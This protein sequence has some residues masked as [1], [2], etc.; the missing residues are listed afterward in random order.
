MIQKNIKQV[1][2]HLLILLS[3]LLISESLYAQINFV[4]TWDATA[5]EQDG[6][7]LILRPVKDVKQT[8]QYLDGLGRPIQT[9]VKQGSLQTINNEFADM[10]APT[11]YDEFG[12]E[13]FKY[14]PFAA[15]NAGGNTSISNGLYKTNALVQQAAFSSI[16]YPGET[17]FYSKT[18]FE[19]SPLNR[20]TDSYAPGSSWA[21]SENNTAALQR[22]VQM[23]Y[24]I[25]TALDDVKI[26]NV[27]NDPVIGNFGTYQVSTNSGGSY[28]AGE[29]Y[30]NITIDE[31]KKQVIE[32][33]D[34][35]GKVIL[36]KVQL[37]AADDNGAGAN[38]VGWLCTYYIY[39]DLN[40]L[41]CVIQP[42]GVELISS[43]WALNDP[44]ILAEQCFRYEYDQR[45]RMII[46]KVPGAGEVYMVYDARD[47]LIMTQDA[48]LRPL[49]YWLVT[50]YDAL[51]R[52]T[53]TGM[54]TDATAFATHLTNTYNSSNYP[55]TTANYEPLSLTHYDDYT[56]LPAGLSA[57]Y[58][59]GYN[60]YFTATNNNNWPYPQMPVQSSATKGMVTWSQTKV[61]GTTNQYLNAVIFYDEKGRAIQTQSINITGGTDISTTQYTWAG[62]PLVM[63]Q[64]QQVNSAANPQE[65]IV[66]SKMEYDDLDRLLATKKAINST[67][68]GVT[69]TKPEQEIVRNQYDKLGQLKTKKLAPAYNS[70]AGLE[71]LTYDYNIR[72][73]L[74]GMNRDFAKDALTATSNYFGFDL[75]YD[76][77][78]NNIIG[79]QTYTNPQYN[80][81]IEGMVWK[82]KGDGEKRK[83][84]F[85]YDNANRLLAADF[86]QYT[87]SVFD[88]SAQVDFSIQ[89]G[90]GINPNLAYDANGNI[91]QMHQWGL[92]INASPLI[93]NL[94]YEYKANNISNRLR[95]VTDNI[96][97]VSDN[98]KLGDF[99]DG[100]NT[101]DDYDYDLNGNMNVDGNKAISNLSYN[102]LNLPNNIIVTSKGNITYTYDAGGN[103][104][105]KQKIDNSVAG[106][107]IT[108]TTKYL[109]GFVYESKT[110][111]PVDLNNP[112]YADVLQFAGHEEGR[113]R[114]KPIQGAI[115]ASFA[116]D[117]MLKDHLGN[118]RAVLTEEIKPAAIYQAG[119]ETADNAFESLLFTKIPDTRA[120][121]P[122]GFEAT[123]TGKQ[124]SQLFSSNTVDKRIGPGILLKV[125]AGDKFNAKVFG[126]YQPGSTNSA[127]LSGIPNIITELINSLS[128]S[129]GGI[130]KTSAALLNTTGAL[131]TPINVFL[132]SQP[133][134]ALGV[135]KAYLN[136][137]VLDEEKF[138]LVQGNYGAVAVPEITGTM[139]KQLMQINNGNDVVVNKNGYLYVY[140]SNESQGNVYFDD[141]RIEHTA[142]AILEETHYYPFGLTMAGISSKAAG[143]I[144]NKY[145][146]N[147]KELQAKE[148]SDGSGLELYDFGA[149]MQDPQI[150]RWQTVDVKA[151]IGHNFSLSPYCAMANNP[152]RYIDPDGQDWV[153]D[154]NGGIRWN[155]KVTAN[156]YQDKGVLSGGQ[157][158]RGTSYERIN[159]WNNVKVGGVVVNNLVLEKYG[160]NK[161]M[162]Y[163]EFSSAS[164][165]VEGSMREGNDKLGDV[166]VTVRAT[167]KSGASR[168]M[169][170]SFAAVAGGFG[171]GA[172]ENGN[173]TLDSYQ[174]RGPDGW[175]NAGMTN[176]GVGFSYNLNPTF[177]TGR[178][179][180]RM[181]PDGNKEG[182]LGCIGISGGASTL[183]ELRKNVNL[184]LKYK[185]SVPTVIS[186][187][188]N[189]N[190][191]G[192]SGNRIPNVNE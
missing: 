17:N 191:N 183:I 16:Q 156:N 130:G 47:R 45:Q 95:K 2:N 33:K 107:T 18:N 37:T 143:G 73:W 132:P 169:D 48:N 188:G 159:D 91:L 122:G 100:T 13:Q 43:S 22:N 176:D 54:W 174:N 75:G 23:K 15:N 131:N 98:G 120:N 59:S 157:I 127:L 150:G 161:K 89:M 137:I 185:T 77:T 133:T 70:N 76:K 114:F 168:V 34:K 177:S 162:V 65:H 138:N 1:A 166:T 92:K 93:D 69:V 39:D 7:A 154:K 42:R 74:L 182:T 116:F 82:S 148:F 27:N 180:L 14:L 64:R 9:V 109:G 192:R 62:Q 97:A 3:I 135:P 26:W 126:W 160:T 144:E 179:L 153:E 79:S 31:H 106:T 152:I 85:T 186:I 149:R 139:Q 158:Y 6:N 170:G 175:Y 81:N 72:G 90:N 19:P 36:K 178:T 121:M 104:L 124:V 118:V 171:N 35:E 38:N 172:P 71:N 155:D 102:Y 86:N 44:I 25:N 24:F 49:N 112:D 56:G 151:D 142:G 20:P 117:Y 129:I 52:P 28:P 111:S 134:P 105:Q 58:N 99:K 94:I 165:S 30:K 8:T 60:S 125:M 101:N 123:I 63:V 187:T 66:I 50:K 51:N 5:P 32:F 141:L 83:Y 113:I 181:H 4:R 108:N 10:V 53:E 68:N 110:T 80:G 167:F 146:Y 145:Q 21:G 128:T 88:K 57:V 189:P 163:D 115:P 103:K 40:Q 61:L 184:V 164:I 140:I 78:N 12:R 46:K 96:A 173:Y 136:Y 119:M 11:V 84:D 67:I 87:G 55:T 29:L 147:G 41:R 190:N